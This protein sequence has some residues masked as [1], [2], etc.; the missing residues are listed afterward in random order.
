MKVILSARTRLSVAVPPTSQLRG[1]QNQVRLFLLTLN[2]YSFQH[3][4]S[5][6]AV[7][8]DLNIL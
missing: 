5:T 8:H 3:F 2:H 7:L 1:V 6:E 4:E